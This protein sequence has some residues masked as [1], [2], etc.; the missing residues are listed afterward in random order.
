MKI[1]IIVAVA[2]NNAIGEVGDKIPWEFHPDDMKIFSNK[3][4]SEGAT[5][6]M[7]RKTFLSLPKTFRPLPSRTNLVLTRNINW[8][9]EGIEVFYS[10]DVLLEVLKQ[11]EVECL[12][13]CGGA[14]VYKEFIDLAEELE[15][16]L[17]DNFMR[18]AL[19]E[20]IA[21]ND[22]DTVY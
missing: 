20:M 17:G 9:Y 18:K 8:S 1:K 4:K 14:E 12:W 5:V 13:V 22:D 11:R 6:V 19:E 10:K 3:T 21:E 2:N 7:G 16:L 15:R